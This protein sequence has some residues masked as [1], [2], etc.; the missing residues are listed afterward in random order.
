MCQQSET[1]TLI[2]NQNSTRDNV[3]RE[4]H[5]ELKD[6]PKHRTACL[7]DLLDSSMSKSRMAEPKQVDEGA[8]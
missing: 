8:G 1:L 2:S 4:A 5:Q 7:R 3:G 6:E